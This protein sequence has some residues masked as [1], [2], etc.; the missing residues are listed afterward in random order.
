[1]SE[2][3]LTEAASILWSRLASIDE[4]HAT[5][6]WHRLDASIRQAR[7]GM[8]S[9]DEFRRIYTQ[10]NEQAAPLIEKFLGIPAEP[11]ATVDVAALVDEMRTFDGRLGQ[12][13]DAFSLVSRCITT[14]NTRVES[15]EKRM[16][17]QELKN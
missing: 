16:L 9:T 1:M 4:E 11:P 6:L 10:I 13:F 2:K 17:E 15:L 12:L 14:I 5:I 7:T 8:I 3:E